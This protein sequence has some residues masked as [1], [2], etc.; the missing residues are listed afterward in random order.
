MHL[1]TDKREIEKKKNKEK[2]KHLGKLHADW[3]IHV[4]TQNKE[5]ENNVTFSSQEVSLYMHIRPLLCSKCCAR[6]TLY[7]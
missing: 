4:H 3:L 6:H 5:E 1:T 2:D 7:L